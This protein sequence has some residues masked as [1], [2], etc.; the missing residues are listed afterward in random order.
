MA[1]RG[2]DLAEGLNES[3]VRGGR[4]FQVSDSAQL[5]GCATSAVCAVPGGSLDSPHHRPGVR[6]LRSLAG[7]AL[8]RAGTRRVGL[9]FP[10]ARPARRR[11]R[12]HRPAG[13]LSAGGTPRG[14]ALAPSR[15]QS[16]V[17]AGDHRFRRPA[18]AATI[19]WTGPGDRASPGCG[20]P[21]PPR[22]GVDAA[23]GRAAKRR[24]GKARFFLKRAKA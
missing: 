20:W 8:C 24:R 16:P 13:L 11:L 2:E 5:F 6:F 23:A 4:G 12:V 3:G 21:A 18:P 9:G 7:I 15:V 1:G 22:P 14:E 10:L 19:V 17:G